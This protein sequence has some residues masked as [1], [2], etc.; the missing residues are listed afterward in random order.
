MKKINALTLSLILIT[1]ALLPALSRAQPPSLAF[2]HVTVIDAT[3]S[4]AKPDMTVVISADRITAVSS[5][6]Q[7][8]IPKDAKVV[9]ATGKYLIPGLWDMHS[10]LSRKEYVPLYLANGV[11]GGRFM[12]GDSAYYQWRREIETNALRGPRMVI[13]SPFFDGPKPI[14]PDASIAIGNATEGRQAVLKVKQDGA[15]FI[16]IYS[17]LPRDAYFAIADEAKQQ[18]IAFAGHVPRSITPAEA[19]NAGQKSIEHLS[20]IPFSCSKLEAQYPSDMQKLQA[21]LARTGA[22]SYYLVYLRRLEAKY[23]DAYDPRKCAPLF[24]RFKKNDTWQVPT[25]SVASTGAL[26]ADPGFRNPRLEYLPA[27]ARDPRATSMYRN[28][29]P[30]DFASLQRI[31]ASSFQI[32]G[33][34]QRAGVRIMAGT[35]VQPAGFA[36]HDELALLVKAGLTPMQALQAATLN[37]ALYFHQERQIGTVETGKLA[38]L[39]LLD[40]DPLADIR[41]TQKI[42]AVVARGRLLDRAELNSMLSQVRAAAS[43]APQ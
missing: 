43:R 18:R 22:P 31:L 19:S 28:F 29:T 27:E 40:A 30:A 6:A 20:G 41:N 16:K 3:G 34:M 11:T 36:L 2:T 42:G 8:T 21:D 7:A 13:A 32:V 15:D 12:N 26:L 17:L 25:L 39:V 35:D 1:G 23:L 37:P 5:S 14:H 4:A 24:E 10:H 33:E 38:D 9:D